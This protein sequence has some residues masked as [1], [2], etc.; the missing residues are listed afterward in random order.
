MVSLIKLD[1]EVL[2][3]VTF[4]LRVYKTIYLFLLK[5]K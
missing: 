3:I 1:L 2:F 5:I 4:D